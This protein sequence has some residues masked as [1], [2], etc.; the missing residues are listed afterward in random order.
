MFKKIVFALIAS[1]SLIS[2]TAQAAIDILPRLVVIDS[3][4]RSGELTVLNMSDE[5]TA[6][7]IDVA[8]LSQNNDGSYTRLES[9]PYAEFDAEENIRFSPRQFTLPPG[10]RQKIR[11]SARRPSDTT[12][13]D[14]HFHIRATEV[15]QEK[16]TPFNYSDE[17]SQGQNFEVAI[18]IA[19]SIPVVVRNGKAEATGEMKNFTL[20]QANETDSGKP[21]LLF[22]V[23]RKGN[24]SLLSKLYIYWTPEGGEKERIGYISNLNVFSEIDYRDVKLNLSQ[25]PSGN[26]SLIAVL[27]D[28]ITGKVL[29]EATLK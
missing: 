18:N 7:R 16:Q 1:L 20:L 3:K 23:E 25:T 12:D 8:N 21:Q 9:S 24:A 29:H 14:H 4:E 13:G 28:A 2:S 26:G 11:V 17:A 5:A 27:K 10:G 19:V 15:K 6:Y 22:Q